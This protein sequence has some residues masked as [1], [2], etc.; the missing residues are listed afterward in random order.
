MCLE[1]LPEDEGWNLLQ[2]GSVRP[3]LGRAELKVEDIRLTELSVEA[4]WVP[5]RHVNLIGWTDD[6][7]HETSVAQQLLDCHRFV[8]KPQE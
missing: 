4:D 7:A 8:A 6:P 3:V 1:E 5:D 2:R